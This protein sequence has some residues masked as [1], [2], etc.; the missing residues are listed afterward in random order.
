MSVRVKLYNRDV[1]EEEVE[2]NKSNN[3]TSNTSNNNQQPADNNRNYVQEY[4]IVNAKIAELER[5]FNAEKQPLLN[6]RTAIMQAA[7]KSGIS[8]TNNNESA[9]HKYNF[10]TKLYESIMT[11][12]KTDELINIINTTFDALPDLSYYMDNKGTRSL[13]KRMLSF[14]NDQYWNDGQDH[15]SDV[16]EF[17]R[18]TIGRANISLSTKEVKK[19]IDELSNQMNGNSMFVWIFG[20]KPI[21]PEVEEEPVAEEEPVEEV[22]PDTSYEGEITPEDEEELLGF[23]EP[24]EEAPMREYVEDEVLPEDTEV[25]S[26]TPEDEEELLNYAE[27][28]EYI[29]DDDLLNES[30]ITNFFNRKRG[31]EKEFY[32]PPLPEEIPNEILTVINDLA[33]EVADDLLEEVN[34]EGKIIGPTVREYFEYSFDEFWNAYWEYF[35]DRQEIYE[36]SSFFDNRQEVELQNIWKAW[37][38]KIVNIFAK[39]MLRR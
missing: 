31:K 18:S 17:V 29:E 13:A 39:A 12:G 1:N 8:L 5:R 30:K 3:D 33:N 36:N 34:N 24:V 14:L 6:Q 27:E 11:A 2:Q 16:A 38:I 7:A 37:G 10:S 21:A 15:W 19:F 4:A 32:L 20:N 9:S 26:I 28:P 23:A 22:N 25:A 35:T